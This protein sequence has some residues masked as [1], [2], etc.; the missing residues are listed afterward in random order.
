MYALRYGSAPVVRATGG[1]RDTVSEFDPA[2]GTGN[3]FVFEKFEAAEMVAALSR[4]VA[5]FRDRAKWRRLMA[6]CFAV[7][8]FVG[9]CGESIRRMVHAAAKSSRPQLESRPWQPHLANIS[10]TPTARASEIL[11]RADGA[12]SCAIPTAIVTELNGHDDTTTNNRMEL[13]GAIEGLRAT[14]RGADVILRSDSQYVV[15]SMTMDGSATPIT[16]CGNCSTPKPRRGACDS[17]GFADTT[18]IR[19]TIAPTNSR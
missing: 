11:G 19:L 18:P 2:R 3:G 13:M 10:C 1:L 12:S 15:K 14:E 9:S 4:M 5:T 17:N 8:F 6:N 16:I 7:G